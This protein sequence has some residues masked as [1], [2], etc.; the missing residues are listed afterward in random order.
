MMKLLRLGALLALAVVL[1]PPRAVAADEFSPAQRAAIVSILRDALKQDPSIL[2]DAVAA[3]QADEIVRQQADSK[4]AIAAARGG[5]VTGADPVAGNAH[6]DVTVV[7]F[8]DTRCPYCRRLEPIMESFLAQDHGVK[9]IYKD[10]PILGPA[11]VLGSKALLAAHRQGAYEKMRDVV[12]QLPPDT[13]PAMIRAAAQKL[14]LD[15]DRLLR[16]MDEPAVQQQIDANLK[17]A[18]G[19]G[20]EGTPALVIGDALIPGVVDVPELRKAVAEARQHK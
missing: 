5:M 9:L 6:G 7:E 11:S 12:M 2:R 15:E 19:L 1:T 18:H 10:L 17:L 8:F 4:A 16:E 20:I 3:L 14:G 13:T